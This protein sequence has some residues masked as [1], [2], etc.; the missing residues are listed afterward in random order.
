M[1]ESVTYQ[2]ILKRDLFHEMISIKILDI[3][4]I[5]YDSK[6][7]SRYNPKI[8]GKFRDIILYRMNTRKNSAFYPIEGQYPESF[9]IINS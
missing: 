8:H 5:W 1:G 2:A 3:M 6:K 9:R 7:V 4:A